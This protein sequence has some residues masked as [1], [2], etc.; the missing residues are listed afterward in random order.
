MEFF[1]SQNGLV[2]ATGIVA[3]PQIVLPK[4]GDT[5][6][7]QVGPYGCSVVHDNMNVPNGADVIQVEVKAVK[8]AEMTLK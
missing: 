3:L 5:M 8:K 2:G 6:Y 4:E 7:I 1:P